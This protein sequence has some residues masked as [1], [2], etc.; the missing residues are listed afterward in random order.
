[1]RICMQLVL[2]FTQGLLEMA[3]RRLGWPPASQLHR[4]ENFTDAWERIIFRC[5]SCQWPVAT[6][7]YVQA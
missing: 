3:A 1:M 6:S 4:L 5:L 7:L 2:Y